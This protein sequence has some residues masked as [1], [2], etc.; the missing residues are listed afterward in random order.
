MNI[1]YLKDR[2]EDRL[3]RDLPG[4]LSHQKMNAKAVSGQRLKFKTDQEARRGAVLILLYEEYSELN[5]VLT[6][7]PD[8][9]GTH[10]GQVSFPGGKQEDNDANLIET[11]LREAEEEI[12]IDRRHV[13]IVGTLS[14]Y[15]V[16][17]SNHLVM[18]VVGFSTILPEFVPDAHEVA[19]ILPV[20]LAHLLDPSRLKSTILEVGQAKF[21]LDAP[22]FDLHD[23]IVWGATAGM[24]SEFK[25]IL[26]EL[27]L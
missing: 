24:L 21:Q 1:S 3:R 25:D 18:P 16:G 14:E 4:E 10:G 23:K 17:A 12:G 20:P 8:Y 7:R 22:Y 15:F 27:D 13:E 6:Q 11:A 19:E 9:N 2:L 26:I 5:F